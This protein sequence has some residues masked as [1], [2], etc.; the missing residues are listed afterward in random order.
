MNKGM[1]KAIE[2]AL[3]VYRQPN[4]F[5]IPKAGNYPHSMLD[6]VKSAAGDEVT[7]QK[8]SDNL[9]VSTDQISKASKFYLQKLCASAGDD[10]LRMLALDIGATQSDIKDHKRWLLKW[11]HPDRNP[12]KWEAKFFMAVNQAAQQLESGVSIKEHKES[13]HLTVSSKA[14]SRRHSR[15]SL[16]PR[17]KPVGVLTLVKLF[18]CQYVSFSYVC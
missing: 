15:Q 2:I 18:F 6:V 11:L 9:G 16:K 7:L 13:T 17:R 12:S 8:N 4:Q 1:T 10:P 3:A 14:S 5:V